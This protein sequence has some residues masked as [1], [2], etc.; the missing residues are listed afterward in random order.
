MLFLIFFLVVQLRYMILRA[1]PSLGE[2]LEIEV[3]FGAVKH[4]R[5]GAFDTSR[6]VF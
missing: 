5:C 2:Q 3:V 4:R 1:V 6:V